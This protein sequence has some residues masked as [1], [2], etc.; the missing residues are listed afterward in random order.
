LII[1]RFSNQQRFSQPK[2]A[3][4]TVRLDSKPLADPA[5]CGDQKRS[6]DRAKTSARISTEIFSKS[7]I[8]SA[9]KN[10]HP[11]HRVS[12]R[13]NHK[14]TTKNHPE[15]IT[16]RKT[17][18]KKHPKIPENPPPDHP[19]APLIFFCQK[20]GLGLTHGLEEQT[21]HRNP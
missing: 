10:H 13:K 4:T 2:E 19:L 14:L 3:P 15:N 18:L 9:P 6:E 21:G 20:T 8:S 5:D 7:G 17:P 1:V 11:T 16:F 12:P